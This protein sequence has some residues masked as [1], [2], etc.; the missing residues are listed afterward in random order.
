MSAVP[1][2]QPRGPEGLCDRNGHEGGRDTDE[3]QQNGRVLE[4]RL[5]VSK[6]LAGHALW[7]GTCRFQSE[8][9][10]DHA[11]LYLR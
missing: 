4:R 1:L 6:A 7:I 2:S 11:D 9:G 8:E 3:R 10:C 5:E